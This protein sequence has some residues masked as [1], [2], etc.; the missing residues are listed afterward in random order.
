MM[1]LDTTTDSSI[2]K[3]MHVPISLEFF[4]YHAQT[5]VRNTCLAITPCQSPCFQIEMALNPN[6][7]QIGQAFIQ[8]VDLD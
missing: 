7:N 1:L 2:R 5:N 3:L 8:Q 6:F 4:T